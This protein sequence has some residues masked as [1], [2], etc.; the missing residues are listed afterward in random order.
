MATILEDVH[1]ETSSTLEKINALDSKSKVLIN[2]CI[3]WLTDR[4]ASPSLIK[5]FEL[6]VSEGQKET[7]EGKP[8]TSVQANFPDLITSLLITFWRIGSFQEELSQLIKLPE[9][10]FDSEFATKEKEYAVFAGQISAH[11]KRIAEALDKDK[12]DIELWC[13]AW[14]KSRQEVFFLFKKKP[15]T[16][17]EIAEKEDERENLLENWGNSP[18]STVHASTTQDSTSPSHASTTQSPADEGAESDWDI[19][20]PRKSPRASSPATSTEI[21]VKA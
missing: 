10:K 14:L 19:E 3:T 15:S 16:N 2:D 18:A 4:G 20:S 12:P 17:V 21:S 13:Q 6:R 11:Q 9:D 1:T 7:R 5:T 8:Q